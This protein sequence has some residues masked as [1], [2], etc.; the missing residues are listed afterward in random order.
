MRLPFLFYFVS[1]ILI[2]GLL[3]GAS[4]HTTEYLQFRKQDK[5]VNVS[6]ET[7]VTPDYV[8]ASVLILNGKTQGS[9]TI[10]S[11]GEKWSLLLTAAHNFTGKIGG[12]FWVYY[13]DGS[14]TE[15][16]LIA[17]DESKDL[18]L[19]AVNSKT[20]ISHTYI[21]TK[22]D[23]NMN[24]LFG[25]GYAG[26][27]GPYLKELVYEGSYYN[28]QSKYR[29]SLNV[30]KGT[31]WDGDSG[32]GVFID[33]A[34][35]GV[36]SQRNATVQIGPDAYAKKL[37]A[38]SHSEILDFLKENAFDKKECGD[39]LKPPPSK[40]NDKRPPL[41]KPSPNIPIYIKS[42]Q[43][44]QIEALQNEVA[45]IKIQLNDL[46]QSKTSIEPSPVER[47]ILKGNDLLKKPSDILDKE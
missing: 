24:N 47:E 10:I 44:K 13:P 11:Q 2:L 20:I 16:T 30:S 27:K 42:A 35:I 32:G 6:G 25:V 46:I 28:A 18:A 17:Y 39:Y 33:G 23:Q 22:F 8:L 3:S 12:K 19:G 4:Y 1:S 5:E 45:S 34:L 26:T 37:Y 29:W 9:G 41:W 38:I 43:D 14:Y 21:P 15:G 40:T 36:T 7:Q 31:L